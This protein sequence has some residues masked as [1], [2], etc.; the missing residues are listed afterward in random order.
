MNQ[1]KEFSVNH[2]IPSFKKTLFGISLDDKNDNKNKTE[3][4]KNKNKED[5][6]EKSS[7]YVKFTKAF[8][9]IIP[10]IS[11]T[12]SEEQV[13]K[14]ETFFQTINDRPPTVS[15]TLN[16]D[17]ND[18]YECKTFYVSSN[19]N[20]LND[21]FFISEFIDDESKLSNEIMNIKRKE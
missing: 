16:H 14:F 4:L 20:N 1:S 5:T 18:N 17:N 9:K 12:N 8:S 10:K 7:G 11:I 21:T 6:K 13:Y 19:Y 15:V 2:P 3:I